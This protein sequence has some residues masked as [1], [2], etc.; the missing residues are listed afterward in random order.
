MKWMFSV[1]ELNPPPGSLRIFSPGLSNSFISTY[2]KTAGS[3]VS[4]AILDKGKETQQSCVYTAKDK[5]LIPSWY[6]SQYP[7]LS[8]NE[9][10]QVIQ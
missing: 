8:Q 5:F 7:I 9:L 6:T 1:S 10:L 4:I 2:W 3:R